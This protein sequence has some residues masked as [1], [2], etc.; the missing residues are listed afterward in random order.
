M[1]QLGVLLALDQA[2]RAHVPLLSLVKPV[3]TKD[4]TLLERLNLGML[5]PQQRA[6]TC[7]KDGPLLILAGAGSGKTRVITHRIGYLIAEGVKPQNILAVSFTNKAA[8]EMVER[9]AHLIGKQYAKEVYLSTFHSLGNDILRRD[10]DALGYKKP[11]TILDDADQREIVKEVFKELNLDPK[12][13]DPRAVLAIISRAKMGFCEPAELREFRF[14]PDTPFAQR[15]FK[16]YQRMLKGR[17]AVDFDDLICLPVRLFQEHEEIRQRYARRFKY[18]MIDEYQDTN[19]TQLMFLNEIVKDHMNLCVVGDDDQSIYGFRGAVAD[20]ILGFEA[21]YDGCVLIKLEQNY[22]STNIILEAA[23]AVIANNTQRK[24]KSLWSANGEGDKIRWIEC[25][26]ER[27]EAEFV[28]A[29]IERLKL[30]LGLGYQNFTILY[31]SNSQARLF[32][33]ALRQWRIPYEVVGGQE[34]YDRKEVKDFIAYLKVCFNLNDENNIRRIVNLPPRGVGPVLMERLSDFAL[35]NDLS[36][37]QAVK[38]AA[39]RPECIEG[40]GNKVST[41]LAEFIALIDHYHDRFEEI[42]K[43]DEG[44]LP[45]TAREL[46]KRLDFEDYLRSQENSN[47][48]ARRRIDNVENLLADISSF[49]ERH[50]GSLDKY[51]TRLMLDRST[52]NDDDEPKPSVRLMTFHSSKGLEFPVVFMVGVEEGYLPHEN[53]K[54]SLKDLSEERRLA[55]VGITRAKE[56]LYITTAAKRSRY[57]KDEVREPS[58]FLDEIPDVLLARERGEETK[59]LGGHQEERNLKYLELAKKMFDF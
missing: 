5:N 53:S 10:I 11:F 2:K 22:R 18:V 24:A 7:H 44:S 54:D 50:G 28:A 39:E 6:A 57:G 49:C 8:T 16:N 20:N 3:S 47:K 4:P 42:E 21:A 48:I 59:S 45:E 52:N 56:H 35:L 19:H 34:F 43:G 36:F 32:E 26:S 38:M 58:R 30:D 1:L 41:K 12:V 15:V 23:N 40:I 14:N 37:Y 33:E 27:D 55:Y 9:V 31:R 29:E 17:N 46:M 13:V 51:L 25:A